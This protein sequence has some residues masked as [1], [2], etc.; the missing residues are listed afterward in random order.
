MVAWLNWAPQPKLF[1]S[2][3]L[4]N[5][6]SN[7]SA[8]SYQALMVVRC[9]ITSASLPFVSDIK[10]KHSLLSDSYYCFKAGES[11]SLLP[12]FSA[13][14]LYCFLFILR[15][16]VYQHGIPKK[17]C[18]L[19]SYVYYQMLTEDCHAVTFWIMPGL[20]V[21]YNLIAKKTLLFLNHAFL[22]WH[23][24]EHSAHFLL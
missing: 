22:W 14:I 19:S 15:T 12:C 8:F 21:F 13:L 7:C 16:L 2:K 9:S 10:L 11:S 1:T 3:L 23:C 24:Q 18:C 6:N 17:F 5:S 4:Y 20:F